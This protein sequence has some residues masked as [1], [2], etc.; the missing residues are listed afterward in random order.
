MF[1]PKLFGVNIEPRCA[2]CEH[3][4][5][6]R[7][8]EA[9]LCGKRGVVTPDYSC[10]KFIYDPISRI[11]KMQPPLMHFEKSDFEL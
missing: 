9:V 2:Y 10:R 1:K 4:T 6:S 7:D 5:L 8:N 11:P 3:G